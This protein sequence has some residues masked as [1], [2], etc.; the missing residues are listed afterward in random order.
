MA[1]EKKLLPIFLLFLFLPATVLGKT[2]ASWT[3]IDHDFGLIKETDGP[4]KVEF[5]FYNKG[6]KDIR[7]TDVRPSCGC[8]AINYTEGKIKKGETGSVT[9]TFDPEERPGKFRKTVAIYLNDENPIEL[10]IQ[11]T[12]MASPETLKLFFPNGS[13]NIR[14]DTDTLRFGEL[15]RGLKRREFIDIY[16]AGSNPVSP[17]FN[18]DSN[19]LIFELS[20]PE[21]PPGE[22]ATLTVYLDSRN[23]MWL[24]D[25]MLKISGSWKEGGIEIP[26]TMTLTP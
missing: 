9:I 15:K 16:N 6:R 4:K 2:D 18:S 23:V 21:I 7:I 12:V 26:V 5:K 14:F 17:H 10:S 11:G 1:I 25:K 24:G 20:Q 13:G 8:T 22:T 19:A 3:A